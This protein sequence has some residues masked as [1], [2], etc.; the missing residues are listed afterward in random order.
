MV[1]R[2]WSHCGCLAQRTLG[3]SSGSLPRLRTE[4]EV[5]GLLLR[6]IDAIFRP[7]LR[8]RFRTLGHRR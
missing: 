4:Y 5:A 3:R 1:P 2:E 7:V 6:A 8:Y